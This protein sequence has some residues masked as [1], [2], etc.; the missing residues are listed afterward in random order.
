MSTNLEDDFLE[1]TNK[2]K[3]NLK[4][5]YD[6]GDMGSLDYEDQMNLLDSL[7][8]NHKNPQGWA[9]S[10]CEWDSSSVC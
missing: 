7:V 10:G 1:M 3:E 6:A 8:E 9:S 4:A 2:L 5:R